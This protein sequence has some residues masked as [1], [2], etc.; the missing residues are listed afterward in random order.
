MQ[1]ES[2]PQT[3]SIILNFVLSVITLGMST[4]IKNRRQSNKRKRGRG[5]SDHRKRND[6]N[7]N[8]NDDN[9]KLNQE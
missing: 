4:I 9:S 6:D 1:N 8:T 7:S 5:K 3:L 2:G